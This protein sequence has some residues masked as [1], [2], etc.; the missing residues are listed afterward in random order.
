VA[1]ARGNEKGRVERAIRF[2][3]ESFFA[4]REWRNLADLNLQAQEWC[5]GEASDR[6]WP[7]DRAS[8][9][10]VRIAYEEERSKLLPLPPV[11]YPCEE[12]VEVTVGKTPY[13]RFDLNDYSVPHTCVRRTLF[14]LASEEIVRIFDGNDIVA[15]HARCFDR[16][17][18]IEDPKHIERLE[19]E[20]AQARRGRGQ[21]RLARSSPS[22]RTL[23]EKLAERGFNLG[24]ATGRLLKLL[25]AYGAERLEQAIAE[26][27]AKET[28][29]VHAVRLVLERDRAA[30]GEEPVIPVVLPAN[31]AVRNVTVRPHSLST[32]DELSSSNTN[33]PT[34]TLPDDDE[35]GK[36]DHDDDTREGDDNSTEE[37]RGFTG[38]APQ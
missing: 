35:K 4:A 7:G 16:G 2:V 34:P 17:K 29:H 8:G 11:P 3:R 24:N 33:P 30:R 31:E 37:D 10:T 27:I 20:K 15:K 12:R 23:F 25:D 38:D 22:A 26:V 28:P 13:I 5:E 9:K 19:G 32:Y 36:E 14:L 6:L 21:D 18:P 1:V